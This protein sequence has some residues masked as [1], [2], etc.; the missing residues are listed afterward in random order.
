M[1]DTGETGGS[2]EMDTLDDLVESTRGPRAGILE[3]I[4]FHNGVANSRELRQYGDIPS[5]VYH[6][7][8]LVEQ[9]IIEETGQE[10]G[11]RG[12]PA[13]VYELTDLG[14]KVADELLGESGGMSTIAELEKQLD[15][16]A[17]RIEDLVDAYNDMADLVEE[18]DARTEDL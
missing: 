9:E 4:R 3:G 5:G 16:Q 11:G 14:E 18:I 12:G 1:A 17:E 7:K 13:T 2:D 15:E 10:H 8:T 6:F